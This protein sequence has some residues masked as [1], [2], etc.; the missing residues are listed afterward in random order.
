ME[1]PEAKAKSAELHRLMLEEKKLKNP[2]AGDDD[3]DE[4]EGEADEN[5]EGSSGDDDNQVSLRS[6]HQT[7][8]SCF[9]LLK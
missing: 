6:S 7:A 4:D 1:T 9:V 8:A 5:E 2:S 3:D